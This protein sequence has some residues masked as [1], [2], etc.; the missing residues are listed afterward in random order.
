LEHDLKRE[1]VLME[2]GPDHHAGM[3]MMAAGEGR[4]IVGDPSLGKG[5]VDLDAPGLSAMEGGADFSS[6]TQKRFDAVAKLAA[7]HGYRVIRMP[8][9]PGRDGKRYLTYVN[10]IMDVREGKPVVYMPVFADQPRLNAA[11]RGIWEGLGYEV[12]PVDCTAVWGQGGTL[13]CLVN[14]MER[15]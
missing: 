11:A 10:V 1:V 15:G 8:T 7:D 5:L 3:Y 4:M 6:E 13:H 2:N 12:K 9:V 14:V